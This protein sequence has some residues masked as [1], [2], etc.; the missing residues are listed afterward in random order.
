MSI[1]YLPNTLIFFVIAA[2]LLV[3][4]AARPTFYLSAAAVA[5]FVTGLVNL[6]MPM[7]SPSTMLLCFSFL[8]VACCITAHHF[9]ESRPARKTTD[10]SRLRRA[11]QYIGRVFRLEE[12]I[13]DGHGVLLA[14]DTV[15][16]VRGRD[17][18]RGTRVK[19]VRADQQVLIVNPLM[20]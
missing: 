9:R 6:A 16:T 3:I 17:C 19:V 15:W 20:A 13:V 1:F 14:D 8:L 18:C 2:M 11:E 5:V 4:E 10:P 12:P 7:L